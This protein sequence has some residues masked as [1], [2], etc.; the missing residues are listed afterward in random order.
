MIS[1]NLT[2]TLGREKIL[3]GNHAR[4]VGDSFLKYTDYVK[5]LFLLLP[6]ILIAG[7]TS[8]FLLRFGNAWLLG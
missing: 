7:S 3:W 1:P 5:N 2:R 8:Y 6:L 4:E